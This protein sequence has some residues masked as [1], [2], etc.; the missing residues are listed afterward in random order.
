MH[1]F[2]RVCVF[3]GSQSGGPAYVEAAETLGRTLA[4]RGIGVVFG[5]GRVGLMGKVADAALAAGGQVIGVIPEKLLNLELAHTGCTE[6]FVTPGMHERKMK[7]AELSDAFVAMPG[8]YGTLEELFEVTTWAQLN[9][10]KKPVGLLNVRGFYDPLMAAIHHANDEGFVRDVHRDLLVVRSEP[11]DLLD[12]LTQ[13]EV[14][15]LGRWIDK[16]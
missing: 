4:K 3:C 7:M 1:E 10:H 9:Y 11:A 13:A 5:G 16:V 6:L 2:R 14:P 15:D 12:A 8:G